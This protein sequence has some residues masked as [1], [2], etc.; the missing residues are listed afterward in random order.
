MSDGSVVAAVGYIKGPNNFIV[1]SFGS[2][3]TWELD[4]PNTALQAR[5]HNHTHTCI[6][7][8]GILLRI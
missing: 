5:I 7:N 4:L 8:D 3:D 1:A 6:R 2:D